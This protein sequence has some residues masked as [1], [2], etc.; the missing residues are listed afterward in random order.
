LNVN[1]APAYTATWGTWCA[2]ADAQ[3]DGWIG[4]Y[5]GSYN[6]SDDSFAGDVIDQKYTLFSDTSFWRGI[7]GHE[8]RNSGY[9]VS[10]QFPVDNAHWYAIWVWSG[11]E[12]LRPGW[13]GTFSGSNAQSGIVTNI[14]YL[15]WT[16]LG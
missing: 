12:Y 3:T 5:V 15:S 13:G 11:G 6:M 7:G 4:L 9:P 8:S 2:Q 10:A 1:S 16:Y 14:P